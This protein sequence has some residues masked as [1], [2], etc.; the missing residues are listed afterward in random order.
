[1]SDVPTELK[2]IRGLMKQWLK[3]LIPVM[4]KIQEDMPTDE[5]AFE[6]RFDNDSHEA[7]TKFEDGL[8][9]SLR[10]LG[11]DTKD[12]EEKLDAPN[13]DFDEVNHEIHILMGQNSKLKELI[14]E[15]VATTMALLYKPPVISVLIRL[16]LEAAIQML[17]V[18]KRKMEEGPKGRNVPKTGTVRDQMENIMKADRVFCEA[19]IN[20]CQAIL[21]SS[22]R[23]IDHLEQTVMVDNKGPILDAKKKQIIEVLKAFKALGGETGPLMK[24]VA[25]LTPEGLHTAVRVTAGPAIVLLYLGNTL[26][27]EVDGLPDLTELD[28]DKAMN[29]NDS[30][31]CLKNLLKEE[32]EIVRESSDV[33][34]LIIQILVNGLVMAMQT[35]LDNMD[36]ESPNSMSLMNK[37]I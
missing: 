19:M 10:A 22:P 4:E 18:R 24:K 28:L 15:L 23:D 33:K 12:V 3:D 32:S 25:Q 16:V 30:T 34:E 20:I 31:V 26:T 21:T 5:K 27:L 29:K 17:E 14:D 36:E 6:E 13:V 7:N 2:N 37:D 35:V 8:L 9:A 1:M 11:A